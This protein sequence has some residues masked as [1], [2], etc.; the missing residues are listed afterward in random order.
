MSAPQV[1]GWCP[2]ALRPMASGD[3]LVVRVRPPLGSLNAVQAPGLAEVAMTYGSGILELTSRANLQIRGVRETDLPALHAALRKLDLLDATPAQEARRNIILNPFHDAP[4]AQ[5]A[6]ATALTEGLWAPDMPTLPGKF[7]FMIDTAPGQRHLSQVSADIRIESASDALIVRADGA[8]HGIAVTPQDAAA[9]ALR[10]A[11]WFVA[12]GG[13]GADGRGRMRR[14]MAHGAQLPDGLAG[15]TAPNPAAATAAPGPT[16]H[17]FCVGAAFGILPAKRLG[18]LADHAPGGL[19]LTPF[20][21]LLLR[22]AQSLPDA[23]EL[24]TDPRDALMRVYACTGAPGC[25]QGLSGTRDLARGLAAD[26]PIGTTL[27]V[28]GCAKGCAHPGA[29]DLTL[30]A[31]GPDQFDL[32]HNGRAD[33]TPSRTKMN[34]VQMRRYLATQEGL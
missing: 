27:H 32:I 18:W 13:I 26:L 10:M 17:G 20:R 23:P 4:D 15:D 2:G 11:R 34:A 8:D 24:L 14:H 21:M 31:T 6:I 12:S 3:G 33:G 22:G 28:S 7:G 1:K 9:T 19:A 16:P 5:A 29:A 30:T 25:P